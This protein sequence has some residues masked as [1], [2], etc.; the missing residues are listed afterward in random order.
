M[1]LQN[2]VC[3]LE[4]SQK[5]KRLG[6][7]QCTILAHEI[8]TAKIWGS[9]EESF[10][11]GCYYI[12]IDEEGTGWHGNNVASAFSV[13]ELGLLL[14]GT[15]NCATRHQGKYKAEIE[16]RNT[17]PEEMNLGT[18]TTKYSTM[19]DTE[20]QARAALLIYLL[21]EKLLAIDTVNERML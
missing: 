16:H 7:A 17:R 18:G 10:I 5:L 9:A 6:V 20:A 13:A 8:D 11:N 4:Q 15:A 14:S 19:H 21:E 3:S 1:K 2:Q 12:G